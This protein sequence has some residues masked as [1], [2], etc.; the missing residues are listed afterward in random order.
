MEIYKA[1]FIYTPAHLDRDGNVLSVE[2]APNIIP[3]VGL[4]YLLGAAFTGVSPFTTWYLGLFD[5]EWTPVA[6]DTMTTLVGNAGENVAYTGTTRQTIVFPAVSAGALS[7][8]ADPNVF[9]F[10]SSETIRG[11]FISSGPTWN[12]TTGLLISAVIFPSPKVISSGE[13]LRVPV[14]FGLVSV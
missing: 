11:A 3:T 7:T 9:E 1:G 2:E 12:N 5:N 10:T 14:G 4:N 6:A 13:S 8:L